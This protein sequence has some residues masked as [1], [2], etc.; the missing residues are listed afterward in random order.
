MPK[1]YIFLFAA[2]LTSFLGFGQDDAILLKGKV[3]SSKNDISNV[4]VV[5][6]NSKKSTITDSLG[7]FSIEV[8]LKD[9]LRIRAV[10]YLPKDI[11][12]S[13]SHMNSS[14]ITIQL[15]DNII[16]LNEVTVTPY[17][18]T[19]D[20]DRDI[21]RLHLEPTVTSYSLGLQNADVTKMTQ[22]ER[23]LQEA[24]RGKYVSLQT[25]D[26]YGKLNEILSY[27]GLTVKV[28]THKIMNR[29]SGRTKSLEEMVKRDENMALE[30]EIIYKFSKQTIA[31]QFNIP[32][33]NVNGF[34]T[35]CLSQPD[36]NDLS[37]SRNMSEI[38]TYLETKS[39]DFKRLDISK[40]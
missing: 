32:E 25:M 23:L 12:I 40:E 28:N 3:T 7:L 13:K 6:L 36:F 15:I 20:I 8:K 33:S 11:V 2:V 38:W 27:V 17:N 34:L 16:D 39:T 31:E 26:E 18:L 35:Y 24:D 14:M 19:G 4:L 5:N 9:S 21:D 1:H 30:K 10:Q 29:F 22:S 37:N